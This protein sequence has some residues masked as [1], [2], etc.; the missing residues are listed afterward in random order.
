MTA[1]RDHVP[2]PTI[3]RRTLLCT[4]VAVGAAG[5]CAAAWPLI[6][7]MNPDA[8][9]RAASDI[10]ELGLAGLR[11]AELR[12]LQWRSLPIFVVRRT[13]AMLQ[14]MQEGS[15]FAR[16]LRDAESEKRQQPAYA[17]NWH[18]SIEPEHGVLIGVCTKCGSIPRYVADPLPYLLPGDYECPFCASR[19]DPAGRVF[20]GPAQ[21]NL[22][23]PPYATG[24]QTLWIGKNMG[25]DLFTLESIERL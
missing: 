15:S 13:A 7:Q 20:S 23:V 4:S 25:D 12:V 19:Y 8:A 11:P 2:P 18:R 10:I 1:L 6:D 16:Q 22:P 14:T 21:Y 5:A 3:S 24:R 9:V 17:R